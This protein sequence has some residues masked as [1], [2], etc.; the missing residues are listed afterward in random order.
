M[1]YAHD[2]G[3][4]FLKIGEVLSPS[5]VELSWM[6]LQIHVDFIPHPYHMYKKILAP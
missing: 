1:G 2:N 4:D 6:K 3:G 5:D